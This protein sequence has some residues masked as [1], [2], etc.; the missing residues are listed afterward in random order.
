MLGN[1]QVVIR[2]M[3][4]NIQSER[5]YGNDPPDEGISRTRVRLLDLD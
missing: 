3:D 5:T 2:T 4:G 1:A